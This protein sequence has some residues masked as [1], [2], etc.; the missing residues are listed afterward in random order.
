MCDAVVELDSNFCLTE[1]SKALAAMLLKS[2]NIQGSDQSLEFEACASMFFQQACT[3]LKH[4]K[5]YASKA[6][7]IFSMLTLDDMGVLVYVCVRVWVC[8]L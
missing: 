6:A 5:T 2:S 7:P 3:I 1:H 4:P 8:V